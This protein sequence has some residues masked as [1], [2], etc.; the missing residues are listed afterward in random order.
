MKIRFAQLEAAYAAFNKYAAIIIAK[1]SQKAPFA[2]CKNRAS[3]FFII[4]KTRV[5]S[6][7]GSLPRASAAIIIKESFVPETDKNSEKSNYFKQ[8]NFAVAHQNE[9][10]TEF[11][12]YVFSAWARTLPIDTL[13]MAK[14]SVDE[15]QM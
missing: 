10:C 7:G 5:Q 4:A 9:Y 8:I 6:G 2:G 14:T 13:S 15:N 1:A 12:E 11:V 3:D